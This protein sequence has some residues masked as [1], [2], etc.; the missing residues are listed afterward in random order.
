MT[1]QQT[2]EQIVQLADELDFLDTDVH[3]TEVV[4]HKQD[5]LDQLC[6][7][8]LRVFALDLARIIT[9]RF[10]FHFKHLPIASDTLTRFLT[11]R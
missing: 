9:G 4:A 5:E 3:G 6:A 2:A 11:E 8:L 1:L 7:K 10:P